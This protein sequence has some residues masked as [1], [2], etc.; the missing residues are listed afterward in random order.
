MESK[1]MSEGLVIVLIAHTIVI[2][3]IVMFGFYMDSIFKAD[4][5]EIENKKGKL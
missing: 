2:G 1:I 5:R 3:L 4:M